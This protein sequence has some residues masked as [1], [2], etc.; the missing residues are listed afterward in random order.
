M[1]NSNS[2]EIVKKLKLANSHLGALKIVSKA[3]STAKNEPK[4]AIKAF[5][6]TMETHWNKQAAK[7]MKKAGSVKSTK[8][9]TDAF[10]KFVDKTMGKF[11]DNAAGDIEDYVE[12][13]YRLTK[14]RFADDNNLKAVEKVELP[15]IEPTLWIK[16]DTEAIKSISNITNNS[17]GAFY[18]T[19]VQQTV[20]ETVKKTMLD[21]T[22]TT[23]QAVEI[24]KKDMAKA[25]KLQPGKLA[26]KVVPKGFNGTANQYFHGLA[27]NSATLARS[28]SSIYSILEVGGEYVISRSLRTAR[29]C[30]GCL[31]M[32]GKKYKTAKVVTHLEKILNIGD[33]SEYKDIQPS[34]HF[35][36]EAEST[37]EQKALAKELKNDDTVRIMPYH[38]RCECYLDMG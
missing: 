16:Q 34:F 10:I 22:L 1:S 35:K 25:L 20:L 15:T 28:S 26:S 32:D 3:L 14:K 27:E 19:S 37:D 21:P 17:T 4:A 31:A 12:Y 9:S 7:V 33:I 24:M 30:A 18:Q 2:L 6:K 5:G 11:G 36:T 8:K 38:F 29:T 23:E 13:I